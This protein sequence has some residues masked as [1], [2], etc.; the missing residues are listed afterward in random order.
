[1]KLESLKSS[2]FEAFKE[3]EIKNPLIVIGGLKTDTTWTTYSGG[4][5]IGSGGD[6][7]LQG[8]DMGDT[9]RSIHW[10]EGGD[11]VYNSPD[12]GETDPPYMESDWIIEYELG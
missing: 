5:V 10:G 9:P 6:M 1:M 8:D 3:N 4:E 7:W 12:G 2:K 11:M